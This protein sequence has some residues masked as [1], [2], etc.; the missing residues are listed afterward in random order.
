MRRTHAGLPNG[1]PRATHSAGASRCSR[2]CGRLTHATQSASQPPGGS[3]GPNREGLIPALAGVAARRRAV[4]GVPSLRVRDRQP[5][6]ELRQIAVAAPPE[7]QV[8]MVRHDAAG[9]NSHGRAGVGL[10]EGMLEELV[11]AV[12]LEQRPPGVGAVQHV[13]DDSACRGPG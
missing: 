12:V 10:F 13:R 8:P 3:A 9:P 2:V 6:H 11:V 5:A 4:G 7:H 1:R